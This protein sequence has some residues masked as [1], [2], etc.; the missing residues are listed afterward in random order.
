MA[1]AASTV[2]RVKPA[3]LARELGVSRQAIADLIRRGVLSQDA[4]GLLDHELA[5]VALANRVR[6]SSKTAKA[7]T[8]A[9][10][11][12]GLPAPAAPPADAQ[13]DAVSSTSYHTAKT[14]REIEEARMAKIKRQQLEGALIE[15][16]PAAAATF[17]AFR[18]LRD[19]CMPIGRRLAAR[20]ATMT[21]AREIQLLIDAEMRGALNTFATRTL[22]SLAAKMNSTTTAPADSG[23]E[24][25]E[26]PTC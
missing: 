13:P 7:L 3:E 20:L 8:S 19:A 12:A 1:S 26:T 17:T 22:A 5:R 21:D 18:S 15:A 4:D 14:L 9:P 24:E 2:R 25:S 6:P 10:P 16:E 11:P 23:T